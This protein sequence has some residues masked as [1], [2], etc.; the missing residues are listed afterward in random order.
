MHTSVKREY[1]VIVSSVGLLLNVMVSSLSR[2]LDCNHIGDTSRSSY[3][4]IPETI[5]WKRPTLK[6][7]GTIWR[8]NDP[9]QTK[10]EIKLSANPLLSL[11]PD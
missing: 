9:D 5:K 11:L 10:E 1:T 2:C 3:E 4:G 8:T 7:G 6:V